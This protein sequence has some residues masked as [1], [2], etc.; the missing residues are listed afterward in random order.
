M[1]REIEREKVQ[2]KPPQYLYD[3]ASM[4]VDRGATDNSQKVRLGKTTIKWQCNAADAT[5]FYFAK[6][7]LDCSL[8][9]LTPYGAPEIFCQKTGNVYSFFPSISYYFHIPKYFLIFFLT[10]EKIGID[11]KVICYHNI[12]N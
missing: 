5:A 2:M 6:S 9:S 3:R 11:K 1:E 12:S 7:R 4:Y 10:L 8:T